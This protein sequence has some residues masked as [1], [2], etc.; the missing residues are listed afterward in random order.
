MTTSTENQKNGNKGKS[1]W[2]FP[3]GYSQALMLTVGLFLNGLLLQAV[4]HSTS[5]HMPGWPVNLVLLLLLTCIT[6]T[7]ALLSR[8]SRLLQWLSSI[9]V[10]F[11]SMTGIGLQCVIAGVIPQGGEGWLRNIIGSWPFSLVMLL[12][13]LNLGTALFRRIFGIGKRDAGYLLNHL[14]IWLLFAGMAFG[15]GDLQKASIPLSEGRS[16]NSGML[17]GLY[18]AE[19]PVMM[20]FEIRLL[21]FRMEEYAPRLSYVR[22]ADGK[23]PGGKSK[24]ADIKTNEAFRLKNW[25]IFVPDFLSEA[26][27][28]S[29]GYVVATNGLTV[30]AARVSVTE[31]KSGRLLAEGWI[32]AGRGV[33]Y[34][35]T[36][37]LGDFSLVM[38]DPKPKL[39]Q[40]D[41]EITVDG[42]TLRKTLRVNEPLSLSG[43]KLYQASYDATKGKNSTASVLLAVKDPWIT[44]VFAGALLMILGTVSLFLT[45][46][47]K[48]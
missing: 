2:D 43:W 19:I 1:F 6:A 8:E 39:F 27:K 44:V 15:S 9:P 12:V 21:D 47:R 26:T 10:S 48:S 16:A 31:A 34:P 35:E 25:R 40:S 38:L 46:I 24:M 41:L 18:G 7:A 45:G 5:V 42:K 33:D 17:E 20:P 3:W 11:F 36:L 4:T 22:T 14:G 23:F 30:P 37:S 32:A 29:N 28:A 13:F